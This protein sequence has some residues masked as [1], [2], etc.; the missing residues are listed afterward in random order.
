MPRISF[1]SLRILR[2]RVSTLLVGFSWIAGLLA[3]LTLSVQSAEAAG[4]FSRVAILHPQLI[5]LCI[6]R[7]IPFLLL[8][9][10]S[11][12]SLSYISF[13]IV[14]S[15]AL[16]Y[17]YCA[18]GIALLFT[19]AG[20]LIGLLLLFSDFIAIVLLLWFSVR[21]IAT[22]GSSLKIDFLLCAVIILVACCIEHKVVSPYLIMLF[23]T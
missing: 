13:A 20:W 10:C 23:N 18:T 19:S 12:F 21:N 3:G 2:R 6:V 11:V 1:I 7:L 4:M 9:F 22:K 14:F 17:S 16:L 5:H 8:A 15:K